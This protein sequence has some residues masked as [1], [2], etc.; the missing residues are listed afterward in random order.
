MLR[1]TLP[2]PDRTTDVREFVISPDGH[3]LA[4]DAGDQGSPRRLWVRALDSLDAQPLTG[5]ED[6]SYPF[7][8]PDSCWIGFFSHDKLKK[9]SVNGG[10]VL[11]LCD[12]PTGR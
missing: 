3:S 11:T 10:P 2:F 7:W 6:A 5:T 4:M 8:S 12:A 1:Y 9:I